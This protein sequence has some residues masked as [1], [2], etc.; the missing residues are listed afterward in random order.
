MSNPELSNIFLAAQPTKALEAG[1]AYII[2]RNDYQHSAIQ[3]N[4]EEVQ[5]D[6]K[7]HFAGDYI[8]ICQNGIYSGSQEH[9][10]A[11]CD[12]FDFLSFPGLP[13]D[14]TKLYS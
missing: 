10:R 5:T 4:V 6:K 8:F 2:N 3:I 13:G 7:K 1:M 12:L 14:K 11:L 9:R